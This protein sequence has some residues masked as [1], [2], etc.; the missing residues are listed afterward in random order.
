MWSD[1]RTVIY[2]NWANDQPNQPGGGCAYQE[3]SSGKWVDAP[4]S[5]TNYAICKISKSKEKQ[6]FV[7]NTFSFKVDF[8]SNFVS[9]E[10]CNHGIIS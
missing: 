4:C 1:D 7:Q 3:F 8:I 5:D 9:L 2:T 6:D 10:K